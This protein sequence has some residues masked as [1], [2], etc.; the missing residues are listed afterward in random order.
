MS[1]S[2]KWD[3]NLLFLILVYI[4]GF[5]WAGLGEWFRGN[6]DTESIG[7]TIWWAN[8]FEKLAV[9][10]LILLST[11]FYKINKEMYVNPEVLE[12]EK[13]IKAAVDTTVHPTT[14]NPF[15]LVFNTERK[16][17][18]HKANVKALLDKLD[19]KA[20]LEDIEAWESGDR[21]KNSYCRKRYQLEK[22]HED[23]FINKYVSTLKVDGFKQIQSTF[24]T[25]GYSSRG[26][27]SEDDNLVPERGGSKLAYDLGPKVL[28][29]IL[30]IT[31]LESIILEAVMAESP[32]VAIIGTFFNV[33]PLVVQVFIGL[34]YAARWIKEKV[35]VDFRKR[36]EIIALYIEYKDNVKEAVDVYEHKTYDRFRT[37]A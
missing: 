29:M 34:S 5:F 27:R 37:L 20:K 9:N 22:R 33:T 28:I 1:L 14:F 32:I 6:I 17:R 21:S 3:W 26:W 19:D 13:K 2:K 36:K 24:V 11:L 25:N 31:A 12:E 4:I 23:E 8:L 18:R 16:I 15:M 10:H 7:S 35:L 30:M